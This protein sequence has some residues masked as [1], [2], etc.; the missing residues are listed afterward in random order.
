MRS[1]SGKSV[2]GPCGSLLRNAHLDLGHT[3]A[4]ILNVHACSWKLW[5]VLADDDIGTQQ[6]LRRLTG[7]NMIEV[8]G[9]IT[10]LV[11]PVVPPTCGFPNSS[12]NRR[13]R[14]VDR[15]V[16]PTGGVVWISQVY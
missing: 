13:I 1:V 10:K 5:A 16:I 14:A 6:I 15:W 4:K 9:S 2:G 11:R 3:R 7:C 12:F 8:S